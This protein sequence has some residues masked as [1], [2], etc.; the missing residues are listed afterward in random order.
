MHKIVLL[1]NACKKSHSTILK[2]QG[3]F[4]HGTVRILV[5]YYQRHH[6]FVQTHNL[7]NS[8]HKSYQIF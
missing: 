6:T 3:I 8:I 4:K 1:K 7:K 5:T 2:I